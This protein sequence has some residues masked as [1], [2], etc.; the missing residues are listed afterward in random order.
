MKMINMEI[1][2]DTETIAKMHLKSMSNRCGI[3]Y[4]IIGVS[5]T[6]FM[7]ANIIK[8]IFSF[9]ARIVDIE[10]IMWY[11]NNGYSARIDTV[12]FISFIFLVVGIG[13]VVFYNLMLRDLLNLCK[14]QNKKL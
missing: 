13:V 12:I 14:I 4:F 3:G 9:D 7:L 6:L 5:L 2:I 1:N 10:K 8:Y 11:Y